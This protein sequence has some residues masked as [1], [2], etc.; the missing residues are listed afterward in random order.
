MNHDQPPPPASPSPSP[1][2]VDA[3]SSTAQPA[4]AGTANLRSTLI[5]T[6]GFLLAVSYPVLA[7][8][9]GVR[10][11]YQLFFKA[12]QVDKLPP[13]LSLIAA[14]SYL[15]ATVGFAIHRPWAWR[16]SVT[17]IALELVG[18]IAVGV[19]SFTHPAVIGHT[20]WRH[21]GEDYG[22]FPLIQPILGLVWLA[23]GP[24]RR[25]YGA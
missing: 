11:G 5:D 23:W 25:A 21:F 13:A 24:T 19:L 12:D 3:P 9:T 4:I 14:F 17:V 7:L 2:P 22:Y 16:L 10:A 15:L 8:S 1:I 6:S 18:V 20:A